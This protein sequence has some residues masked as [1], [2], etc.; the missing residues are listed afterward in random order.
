MPPSTATKPR[1]TSITEYSVTPALAT[2]ARPGSSSSSMSSPKVSCARSTSELHPLARL[3]R[4]LVG[5][6]DAHAAAE[7][8]D[9]ERPS[10]AQRLHR[11][12]EGREVEELGAEV[13]VQAD[14][15][16]GRRRASAISAAA[17]SGSSPNFEVVPPVRMPVVSVGVDA[18]HDA[19]QAALAS[20]AEIGELG[21]VGAVDDDR[22]TPASTAAASSAC[23]LALPCMTILAGSKPA[24]SARCSSPPE[25]TSTRGRPRRRRAARRCRG[26]PW[27]R[28]R[29]RRSRR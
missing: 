23:D 17:S 25:A 13:A 22:P 1:L 27:R 7:V 20:H 6:G 16:D 12:R 8:V 19:H 11:A 3:R 4:R 21:G 10:A 15:V 18:G 9:L 2:S 29:C 26:R 28:R 5:V 14:D 24:F